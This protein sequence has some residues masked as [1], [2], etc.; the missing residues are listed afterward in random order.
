MLTFDA[1]KVP[2]HF[3]DRQKYFS[4]GFVLVTQAAFFATVFSFVYG[5]F[6]LNWYILGFFGLI[7]LAQLPLR[8]NQRYCRFIMDVLQPMKFFS[9]FEVI[10]DEKVPQDEKCVFGLH[11]HSVFSLGALGVLHTT[12]TDQ[13]SNM[14]LL[15][16][17]FI[18]NV[19]VAGGLLRR[20]GVEPV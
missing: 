2:P 9:R 3:G 8:L 14:T 19:P 7:F 12:L 5:L 4:A 17:R 16:S 20:W 6:T 13:I 1:H 18:L 15:G 11:P 10:H